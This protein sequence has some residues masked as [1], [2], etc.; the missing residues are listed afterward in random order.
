VHRTAKIAFQDRAVD[1]THVG[2]GRFV[3]DTDDD[4]IGV[5][6]VFDGGAFTQEFGI[7]HDAKGMAAPA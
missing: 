1:F 2:S 6:E 3:F 5:E 7:R 4:A